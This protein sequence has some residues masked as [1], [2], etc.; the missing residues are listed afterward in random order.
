MGKT[1]CNIAVSCTTKTCLEE[2]GKVLKEK[3][4]V[5]E[6]NRGA[7]VSDLILKEHEKIVVKGE[8]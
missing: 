5:M 7:F 1:Y 2:I 3:Y 6:F 4:G 8:K